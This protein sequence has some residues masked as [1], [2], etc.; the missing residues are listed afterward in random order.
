MTEQQQSEASRRGWPFAPSAEG[1]LR[2][3][4]VGFL[5]EDLLEVRLLATRLTHARSMVERIGDPEDQI[6]ATTN[7]ARAQD[8]IGR[9][10]GELVQALETAEKLSAETDRTDVGRLEQL[11][12]ELR[13]GGTRSGQDADDL[14]ASATGEGHE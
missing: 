13:A 12:E 7:V 1:I 9:S 2:H 4:L 10:V 11:L 6:R 8:F 3:Q 5:R 14:V